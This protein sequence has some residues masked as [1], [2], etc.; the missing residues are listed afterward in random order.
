LVRLDHRNEVRPV[1]GEEGDHEGSAFRECGIR[2]DTRV[3]ETEVGGGH[4]CQAAF[5]EL[6]PPAWRKLDGTFG[7]PDKRGFDGSHGIGRIEQFV[8]VAFG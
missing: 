3:A 8:D 7:H 2:L 1:G 5:G 6:Q 4:I